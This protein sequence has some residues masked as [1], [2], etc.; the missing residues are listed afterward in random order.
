LDNKIYLNSIKLIKKM[1]IVIM[2]MMM[3]N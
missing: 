1:M 2:K 3:V